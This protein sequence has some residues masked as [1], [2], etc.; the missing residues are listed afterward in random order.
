[1]ISRY[2]LS[3]RLINDEAE[4]HDSRIITEGNLVFLSRENYYGYYQI[5]I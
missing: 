3:L 2:L 1:M 5:I 4:P